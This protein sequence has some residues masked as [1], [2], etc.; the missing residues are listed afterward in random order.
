[1]GRVLRVW[2]DDNALVWSRIK[3]LRVEW[4]FGWVGFTRLGVWCMG[5]GLRVWVHDGVVWLSSVKVLRV[6]GVNK[7]K[8]L[9]ETC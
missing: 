2:V 6:W 3:V 7:V 1:M 8:K 5:R 4:V 9:E